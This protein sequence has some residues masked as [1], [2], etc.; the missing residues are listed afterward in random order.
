MQHKGKKTT[1]KRAV[2][3]RGTATEVLPGVMEKL[4][5]IIQQVSYG[6]IVITI[7]D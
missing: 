5:Q 2:G 6:E 3:C 7:H 4:M 1:E